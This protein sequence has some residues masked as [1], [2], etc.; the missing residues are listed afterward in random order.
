MNKAGIA[1]SHPEAEASKTEA[2]A[3][4]TE[5]HPEAEAGFDSASAS[6]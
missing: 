4:N 1:E 5:S 6:I 3:S 2:E